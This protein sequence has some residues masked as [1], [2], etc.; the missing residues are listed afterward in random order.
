MDTDLII[1]TLIQF[2]ISEQKNEIDLTVNFLDDIGTNINNWIMCYPYGDYNASLLDLLKIKKC[3]LGFTT[4]IDIAN[5]NKDNL[6]TLPRLDTNFIQI[7]ENSKSV[8]GQKKL[9]SLKEN[10]IF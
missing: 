1:I 6:L 3:L 7:I 5:L 4:K 8:V 9:Y 10:F 2:V